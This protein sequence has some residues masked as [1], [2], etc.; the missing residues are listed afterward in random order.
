MTFCN[1]CNGGIPNNGS[2]I[3]IDYTY[4]LTMTISLLVWF[5]SGG[6]FFV[7]LPFEDKKILALLFFN[8]VS[9]FVTKKEVLLEDREISH[10]V[11]PNFSQEKFMYLSLHRLYIYYFFKIEL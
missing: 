8:E 7:L 5:S 9:H 11:L 10:G 4:F 1:L 2:R 3:P 6:A